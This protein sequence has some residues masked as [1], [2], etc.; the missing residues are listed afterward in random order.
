MKFINLQFLLKK[1]RCH[2]IFN[3]QVKILPNQYIMRMKMLKHNQQ[4]V[5]MR[6]I[7]EISTFL[8]GHTVINDMNFKLSSW[9]FPMCRLTELPVSTVLLSTKGN[10]CVHFSAT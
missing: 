8:K 2:S 10:T 3:A 4:G 7:I 5:V 6:F 9:A 1:K